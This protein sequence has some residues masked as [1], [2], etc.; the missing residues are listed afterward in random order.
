MY[1]ERY[2]PYIEEMSEDIS[3]AASSLALEA[4]REVPETGLFSKI[5]V[6]FKDKSGVLDITNWQLNICSLYI[7]DGNRDQRYLEVSGTLKGG[8][9]ISCFNFVGTKSECIEMLRD[10]SYV[11]KVKQ[12]MRVNLNAIDD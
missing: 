12:T 9:K 3:S 4:E 10:P 5:S 7:E 1:S 11:E 6:E 2:E 8:Y